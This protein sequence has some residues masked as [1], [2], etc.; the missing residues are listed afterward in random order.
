[1]VRG[2]SHL[3]LRAT[4]ASTESEYYYDVLDKANA[5]AVG[6]VDIRFYED[7]EAK[8]RQIVD[9]LHT[10]GIPIIGDISMIIA[11]KFGFPPAR[12]ACF[13]LTNLQQEELGVER[14]GVM[15]V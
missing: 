15:C 9:K 5:S 1:M 8:L 10:E 13:F 6:W 4:S 3:A 7:W 12:R 14:K 2:N 11:K